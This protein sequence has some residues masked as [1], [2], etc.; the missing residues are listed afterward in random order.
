LAYH[1]SRKAAAAGENM[2]PVEVPLDQI[3]V[4]MEEAA[5]TSP[6]IEAPTE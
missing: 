4:P 5:V 6:E 3:D 1:E 2:D